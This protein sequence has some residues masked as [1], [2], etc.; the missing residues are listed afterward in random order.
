M[1]SCP[2][3]RFPPQQRVSHP[4]NA[5]LPSN[6][7]PTPATRSSPATRF[8]QQRVSPSNAFGSLS[9]PQSLPSSSYR[10]AV[11]ITTTWSSCRPVC[12]PCP[13]PSRTCSALFWASRRS[14]PCLSSY[15]PSWSPALPTLDSTASSLLSS[16]SPT[17]E[18]LS[19]W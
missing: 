6:A 13:T 9:S 1:S 16:T 11:L 17:L 18:E 15:A 12:C 4:N 5:F 10:P 14:A 19:L 2:T 8:P 7:F 3:T